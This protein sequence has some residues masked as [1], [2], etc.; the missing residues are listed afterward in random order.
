MN[1]L[2]PIRLRTLK[3]RASFLLKDIHTPSPASL[4]AAT[5]LCNIPVFA[6]KTAQWLLEHPEAV[7]LKH[8]YQAIAWE[9]GFNSWDRLKHTIVLNDCLYKPGGVAYIHAWFRDY[10]TAE[11]YF[12]QHGGF[13][14]AFW[15]DIVVCGKEYIE[16][17]ELDQY[18][19]HWQQIGYNWIKP[20][21][22]ASFEFL[23]Q[24]A[25]RNYLSQQ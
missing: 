2:K 10:G 18:G 14:L 15:K 9:M 4:V 21:A 24:Q 11:A 22:Q 12:K 8:A 3:I 20:E 13:L 25:I 23:Q 7:K 16:C 5:T 6:G 1:K 17:L 19:V